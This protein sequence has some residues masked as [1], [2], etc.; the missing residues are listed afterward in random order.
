[1]K[2]VVGLGNPGKNYEKNYHNAGFLVLDSFLSRYDL[3]LQKQKWNGMYLKARLGGVDVIFAKPLTFMNLSGNFVLAIA[4]YFNVSIE[5]ILIIHDDKD[6]MIN[7]FKYKIDG[8]SGGQNGV[9]NIIQLLNSRSF[10]RLRIGVGTPNMKSIKNHV[11]SNFTSTQLNDLVLNEKLLDSIEG[12]IV[13]GITK[14]MN[15]YNEK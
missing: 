4:S 2:L 13:E 8:G 1:M 5:D 7:K 14:T 10:S 6:I 12:W 11:L 9:A 3:T 15:N